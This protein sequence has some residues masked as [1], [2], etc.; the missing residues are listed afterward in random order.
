MT[1]QITNL[2]SQVTGTY[3][4]GSV[5][6]GKLWEHYHHLGVMNATIEACG[7]GSVLVSQ[8]VGHAPSC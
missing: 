3:L 6:F 4:D 5:L 2:Q 7:E 8:H 1:W